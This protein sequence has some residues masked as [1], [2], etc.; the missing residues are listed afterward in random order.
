MVSGEPFNRR[1]AG[2]FGQRTERLHGQVGDK[3]RNA[4]FV[5][6]FPCQH[7][8]QSRRMFQ[9]RHDAPDIGDHFGIDL[10]G[11]AFL[12]TD[13][14]AADHGRQIS[15][16]DAPLAQLISNEPAAVGQLIQNAGILAQFRHRMD[17]PGALDFRLIFKN[18]H[19]AAGGSRIDEQYSEHQ[20][21]S[22]KVGRRRSAS[23]PQRLNADLCIALAAIK[24]D[25]TQG[26]GKLAL[27]KG[28]A[29]D[30]PIDWLDLKSVLIYFFKARR[31]CVSKETSR[32]I[33]GNFR[34]ANHER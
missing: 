31:T 17:H 28:C 9:M 4:V 11:A 16:A 18:R 23:C 13:R 5:G 8:A 1:Q 10:V 12:M 7:A 29:K 25:E 14:A 3:G 19:L 33:T 24:Q 2:N 30:R 34:S 26:D 32:R 15:F 20:N 22:L 27:S 21:T 6:D